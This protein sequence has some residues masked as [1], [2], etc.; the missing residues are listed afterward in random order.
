MP[1]AL[2]HE[3]PYWQ[4]D[5]HAED[6]SGE[7][8]HVW[9][10]RPR[11]VSARRAR[12][13][14][15]RGVPLLPLHAVRD[16]SGGQHAPGYVEP[17]SPNGRA[18][19]AWFEPERVV[20]NR[21]ARRGA[22]CYET[23]RE[24][25]HGTRGRKHELATRLAGQRERLVALRYARS[26]RRV[27]PAIAA[28]WAS[29]PAKLQREDETDREFV[30]R[31]LEG[32]SGRGSQP[33]NLPRMIWDGPPRGQGGPA[34]GYPC[35]EAEFR[36]GLRYAKYDTPTPEEA[37]RLFLGLAGTFDCPGCVACPHDGVHPSEGVA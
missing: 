11:Y 10:G 17:T 30:R 7:S 27:A 4:D 34:N 5:P 3:F 25:E 37:Q 26:W 15:K 9:P 12:K 35:T 31:H 16:R 2:Q 21:R 32:W 22:A 14:R 29:V 23:W 36:E 28:F 24:A 18:R 8:R 33:H 6:G 20:E 1:K 13:L 19:Y